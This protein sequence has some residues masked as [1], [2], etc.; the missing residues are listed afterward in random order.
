[1]NKRVRTAHYLHTMVEWSVAF[2]ENLNNGK[3]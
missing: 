3:G 1:L 2:P